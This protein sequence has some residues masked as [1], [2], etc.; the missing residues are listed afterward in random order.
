MAIRRG[1][2]SAETIA[3]L[4]HEM[5]TETN[6]PVHA[7]SYEPASAEHGVVDVMIEGDICYRVEPDTGLLFS[8][9][10]SF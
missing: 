9:D 6:T 10:T 8:V 5:A 4:L 2:D 1:D 3:A 7:L